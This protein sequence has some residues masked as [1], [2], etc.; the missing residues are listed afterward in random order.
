M[1]AV[2]KILIADPELE[3]ARALSKALRQRGYQVHFA[4]DGSRAL[5]IAVLRHPDLIL[6]DE[7]CRLLEART[8]IQRLRTNPRTED[9]PVVLTGESSDADKMRGLRDGYLRKPFNLDEVLAR[10]DHIFRRSEAAR[11]LK[12]EAKELE[13]TL[14][15]FSIADL[16]QILAMNRRTGRLNLVHGADRGDIHVAEGRPVNAHLGSVE[17]EKALFRMLAWTDGSFAFVPG[18]PPGKHRI[19]RA[20][21]DAL[22]EGMRQADEVS[23][24]TPSMPPRD[25]TLQLVAEARILPT[26]HPVTAQV[27]ELLR[28]PRTFA[29]VMD[30]TT[31]TDLDAL[32]VLTT[33][34]QKGVARVIETEE[35]PG[36][37]SPLLGPADVHALRTRLFRGRVQTRLAIAKVFLVG[38]RPQKVRAFLRQLPGLKT[39]GPE[40]AALSEGFGTLARFDIGD[41]LKVDFCLLPAADP[42]RPLWRPFCSGAVGALVLDGEADAVRLGTFLG[43]EMGLPLVVLAAEV[44]RGLEGAP[45]G[46]FAVVKGNREALAALLLQAVSAG[47][48]FLS[49]G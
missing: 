45:A 31:A 19:D 26:Q 11:D 21:D 13:G 42:A 47:T 3:A 27:M 43:W 18:I 6:F 9:I 20:M 15:Q 46:A 39:L 32:V 12:G 10:I 35:E 16:L 48:P 41:S 36:D 5:E 33:L 25:A 37:G 28:Q 17:G 1:S 4:A 7:R 40:P 8:F 29:E 30:L 14:T 44:P 34:L 22:L 23:R 38:S 49:L 24:L 2:R